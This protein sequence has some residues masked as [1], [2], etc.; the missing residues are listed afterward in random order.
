MYHYVREFDQSLPNFRFLDVNDFKKQLD[1]FAAEFG[2]VNRDEWDALI[3]GELEIDSLENKV[4][5]TF[6]DAMS[7]HFNYVYPE[8][9]RRGLW[10][11]FYIPAMP[12]VEGTMLDVHKIHLLCGKFD[13]QDLYDFAIENIKEHMIPDEKRKEFRNDTYRKQDNYKG[14][15]EFKR[16]LNYFIDYK[17][18]SDFIEFLA[19]KFDF[20]FDVDDFYVNRKDLIKMESDGNILGSHSFTHP[21]MSKKTCKEQLEEIRE[22]F[23][24]LNDLSS[25]ADNNTY[26]HPYG[27]FHSF[28]RNTID[29]LNDL[30]VSYSF[31]VE[32]RNIKSTDLISGRQ[33]LP[34]YDCNEF[35][36]G[37]AS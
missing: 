32:S 34:R 12:Y 13:G 3:R 7:C 26:C 22:S 6:D 35:P 18:R 30:G 21:V 24:F 37:K 23:N 2:F 36:Y 17:Y 19:K 25:S 15:S 8:L 1:Y 9:K 29:I 27:G 20:D 28:D 5:L 4:I 16:L 33:H 11:I 31:N 10:G 14:V